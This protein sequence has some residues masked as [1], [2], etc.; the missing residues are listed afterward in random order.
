VHGD[1]HLAEVARTLQ[2]PGG[3]PSRLNGRQQQRDEYPD[4]RDHDQKFDQRKTI[5]PNAGPKVR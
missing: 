4:D 5:P 3:L 1:A 2:P